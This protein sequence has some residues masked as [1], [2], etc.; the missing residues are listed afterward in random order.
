MK[1]KTE[2]FLIQTRLRIRE[3]VQKLSISGYGVAIPT[4]AAYERS[5]GI[6]TEIYDPG[7][8]MDTYQN[9]LDKIMDVDPMVLG[10]SRITSS[11]IEDVYNF[12][13]DIRNRGYKGFIF[14]GGHAPSIEFEKILPE[15]EGLDCIVVGEGEETIYNLVMAI[16]ENKD[17]RQIDGIV[18]IDKQEIRKNRLRPLIK[19]LDELPFMATDF[20]EEL[21]EKYKKDITAYLVS[22]RGCYKKCS[23]CSIAAYYDMFEG[24]RMRYRSVEN[25]FQEMKFLYDNYGI[26]KFCFWDDNFIAYGNVGI[27]RCR[28]L[29]KLIKTLPE[30]ISIELETR[31]DTI[32][33]EVIS[34]LKEAGLKNIHLGIESFIDRDLK[35]YNKGVTLKQNITALNILEDLGF[36]TKVGSQYRIS[37]YLICFNPY[38][39]LDDVKNMVYY[40][41]KY[42]ISP[43]KQISILH[44]TNNTIIKEYL[45]CHGIKLKENNDWDFLDKRV[46]DVYFKY[47]KFVQL[48][49]KER[50]KLR[51]I[52]KSEKFKEGYILDQICELRSGIDSLCTNCL[53]DL[54]NQYYDNGNIEKIELL[55]QQYKQKFYLYIDENIS[56]EIRKIVREYENIIIME[57]M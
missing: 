45:L 50:E 15:C 39:T 26:R 35:L 30:K 54:V 7:I 20:L 38:T 4:I 3:N 49:M 18:Y 17:W 14:L 47:C 25:V 55:Y 57:N 8:T 29:V 41:K 23:F 52:E 51:A 5:K 16:R 31:V 21:Q 19:N 10:I 46:S 24:S 11:Y 43:K 32:S 9:I 13:K 33:Y 6:I 28:S 56:N 12:V 2:L 40:F 34:L 48:C 37:T 22:S 53:E 44:V 27:E 1:T 42:N 36:S